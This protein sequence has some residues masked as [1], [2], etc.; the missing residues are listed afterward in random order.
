MS[1]RQITESDLA[2][3]L[4]DTELQRIRNFANGN[5]SDP[6]ADTLLGITNTIRGYIS[7][8]AANV[9]GPD[10]TLPEELIDAACHIAV[11]HVWTRAGG[12]LIDPEGLR[13]AA[14]EEATRMLRQDVAKGLFRIRPPDT[15]AQPPGVGG[16]DV[17]L[18]SF[19]PS[20]RLTPKSL[21]GLM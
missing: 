18:A 1:W 17:E 2:G 5:Q 10:G 14:A 20:E 15:G 19:D 9:L 16:S 13:K 6:I 11:V 3:H 12:N 4:S 7:A 21:N 8:Y